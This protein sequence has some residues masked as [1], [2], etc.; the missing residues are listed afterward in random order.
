MTRIYSAMIILLLVGCGPKKD[1]TLKKN[2]MDGY[3]IVRIYYWSP[4][5]FPDIDSSGHWYVA[6]KREADSIIE[7]H[8]K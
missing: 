3:Y 1:V 4:G 7:K 8:G 2:L 6:T 5:L